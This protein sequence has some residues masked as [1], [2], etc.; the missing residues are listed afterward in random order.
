MSSRLAH[1]S[2]TGFEAAFEAV[3]IEAVIAA[4]AEAEIG[5]ALE[6]ATGQIDPRESTANSQ[7]WCSN[8]SFGA[9]RRRHVI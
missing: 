4:V 6:S 7:Q 2:G 3:V 1:G 8:E 9:R 5:T